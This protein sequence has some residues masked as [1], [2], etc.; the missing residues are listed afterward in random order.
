[1]IAREMLENMFARIREQAPWNIDDVCLWG[2]FF[3]DHDKQRLLAAA[4][5]LQQM[6]YRVVGILEPTPGDDDQDLLFLHVE[7]EEKHTV[8]S[9]E[10]RNQELDRFAEDFG[11][12]SYDGMDV[13]PV[14][15]SDA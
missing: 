4:P 7:R 11:L 13:G 14:E 8:D 15:A 6:G 3:T 10:A 5:A 12:R 1:M 9:L 2:Y